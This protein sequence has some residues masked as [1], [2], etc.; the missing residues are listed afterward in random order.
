MLELPSSPPASS[1]VEHEGTHYELSILCY[2]VCAS[3]AT[4]H[5]IQDTLIAQ[6]VTS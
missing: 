2:N 1:I 3:P 5:D 4:Y 6:L